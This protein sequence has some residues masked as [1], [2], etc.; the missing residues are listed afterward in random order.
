MLNCY[1]EVFDGLSN[2]QIKSVCWGLYCSLFLLYCNRTQCVFLF[3]ATF[4]DTLIHKEGYKD[5]LK[6][7]RPTTCSLT[8]TNYNIIA[9]ASV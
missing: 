3:K 4:C 9:F 5:S 6:T 8:N 7:Y 2:Y 1:Q